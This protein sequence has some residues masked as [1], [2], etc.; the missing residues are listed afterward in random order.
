MNRGKTLLEIIDFVKTQ[1]E[2][3]KRRGGE[4]GFLYI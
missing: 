4:L 2:R 1:A 3:K